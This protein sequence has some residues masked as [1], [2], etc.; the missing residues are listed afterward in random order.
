MTA[1]NGQDVLST[2]KGNNAG[3]YAFGKFYLLNSAYETIKSIDYPGLVSPN[4]V[5]FVLQS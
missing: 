2:W 1:F 4:Y 5:A 3:P